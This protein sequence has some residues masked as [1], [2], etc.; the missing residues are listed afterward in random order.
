MGRADCG[1]RPALHTGPDWHSHSSAAAAARG[2]Y[3]GCSS[4]TFGASAP[5]TKRSVAM[6][7]SPQH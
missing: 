6:F 2:A 3:M 5:G 1:T 7:F 4:V